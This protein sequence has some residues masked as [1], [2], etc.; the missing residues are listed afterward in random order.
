VILEELQDHLNDCNEGLRGAKNWEEH[1]TWMSRIALLEE[2]IPLR[3]T[4][5]DQDQESK[6]SK[7]E[8]R[9]E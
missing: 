9:E 3:R 8:E 6:K 1:V 2:M 4:L 5:L 7:L